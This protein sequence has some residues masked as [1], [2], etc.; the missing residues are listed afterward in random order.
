MSAMS[1]TEQIAVAASAMLSYVCERKS[2]AGQSPE[3]LQRDE[4]SPL[5][6]L[7]KECPV[8]QRRSH[9]IND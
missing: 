9:E 5:Q 2:A 6:T 7:L 8:D 3:S 1:K 4:A